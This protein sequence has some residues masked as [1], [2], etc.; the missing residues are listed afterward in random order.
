MVL[1]E[2][3]IHAL[4][5]APLLLP[6]LAALLA[7][8]LPRHAARISFVSAIGLLI[9][10]VL[11]L[12][13]VAQAGT[14]RTAFGDWPAP[15]GIEFV[16]DP[17]AVTMVVV[18][19]LM[20]V[21]CLLF[22]RSGIDAAPE[23][24]ALHPLLQLL[25]A[26][27]CG[28]F[29][30]GDIF[31]LYVWFELM[32]VAAVG[33]LALGA[34]RDQLEG[35]FK[36]FVLNALGTMLFLIA[37]GWL[38][39]RVGHLNYAA[40]EAATTGLSAAE[41]GLL[42]TALCLGLLLKA[43]AFPL[44]AWLPASY[45]TLPAPMVAL[46]SGL[47]T[48]AGVYAVL[49][50]LGDVFATAP[51]LV[52]TVLGWIAVATMVL[53]VLGAAFH[54]DMRRILAVHI[55]SQIGYMLLGIALNSDEGRMGAMFYTVHNII[56]KANLF[57]VAALIAREIGSYDLRQAGGLWERRPI[58]ALCFAIP[59]LSMVGFPPLSGF[60]AKFLL[61]REAAMLEHWL[62]MIAMLSVGFLTMYSM[63][64]IWFEAFWKPAPAGWVAPKRSGRDGPAVAA[65]VILTALTLTLGLMPEPFL[66]F[67]AAANA[68]MEAT[69]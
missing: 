60:W 7:A 48:K 44:F 16:A 62:W 47:L 24:A 61:V 35:A 5:A 63:M 67:V 2:S 43:G 29:L 9:V 26:G 31:N 54:W 36:Y 18:T 45:H 53:G 15:F 64:K 50:L 27:A 12:A 39:A 17:L 56:V 34:R 8:L 23:V 10:A 30:T 25:L 13:A 68:A 4:V 59:A 41:I 51:D 19:A 21:V 40:I 37:I 52:F 57:L 69:P 11:L 58:L 46:F 28:A 3:Q 22:Q 65:C 14:L 1:L 55:I 38:Y 20:A 32:L 42:A 49:R 66:D 6:M 33:L